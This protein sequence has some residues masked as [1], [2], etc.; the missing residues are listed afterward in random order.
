VGAT[1]GIEARIGQA[2]ALDGAMVQE[3][4]VDDLLDV[5]EVDEAV[6]DSLGID[7]DDGPV[8]TLVEAAGLVGA[9]VMLEASLLDGILEGRF[10]LF[11]SVGEAAGTRGAF[12]ALVDA[13]EDMV[14]E[15]RHWQDTLPLIASIVRLTGVF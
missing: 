3:V 13:D 9:D 5:L 8:L 7:H 10:E 4:L 14:V 6:P 12:V 2:K 11:A 15:L 1:L